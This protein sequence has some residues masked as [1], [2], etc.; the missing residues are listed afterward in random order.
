MTYQDSLKEHLSAYKRSVLGIG[1][2]G[3]YTHKGQERE[4]AHILPDQHADLNL[5][6]EVLPIEEARGLR[7]KRHKDFRHLNSSQAFAYNLFLPF[8]DGGP[9]A[10]SALLRALGQEGT[11][12]SWELEAVP[13]PD[14]GSNLDALWSTSTGL[15][16][17]CEVKLSEGEFGTAEND[18][19]HRRKLA[20]IYRAGLEGLVIPESLEAPAFFDH[21]QVFRNVW[22]MARVPS[23]E[24]L[25]LM[26]RANRRLW[27]IIGPALDRL[28]PGAR[29]RVRLVAIEDVLAALAGDEACPAALREYTGRLTVKYIMP[30]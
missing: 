16:T 12:A 28:L 9:E 29:E 14:E 19:R 23:S 5:F 11:V 24:L 10:G 20:E 8:F 4:Y 17:V 26:P 7:A 27:S 25:F 21:Y 13:V 3:T 22:H 6:P 1:E 2:P 18:D 15:G 30:S